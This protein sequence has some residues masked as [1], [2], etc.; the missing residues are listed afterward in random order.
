MSEGRPTAQEERGDLVV[1]TRDLTKCYGENVAVDRLNLALR[2]GEVFGLL[3]PNGAG[4]TTTILML[5]GLTEPTSGKVEVLGLD[6]LTQATEVKR[7]VGYLPDHVGFYDHM[8]GLENLLYTAALND[9]EP[10]T[11]RARA[12][13]LLERVGLAADG[14]R[15]VREYSHGMRQRLGIADALIKEPEILILDEPTLGLDPQGTQDVLALIRELANDR[16]MTIL[17]SSHLLYQVQAVCDRVGIFVRGRMVVE[18]PV[19]RLATEAFAGSGVQ[20][21]VGLLPPVER[22]LEAIRSV[23]GVLAVEPGDEPSSFLV[24]CDRDV[25]PRIARAVADAGGS[26]TH[27]QARSYSLDDIYRTY[28]KGE[29]A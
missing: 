17:L 23:E 27:L 18:G 8:T 26:L 24:R 1:Q 5:L 25:R 29:Q 21:E 2:R 12:L 28:F 9:L 19:D 14:D 22:A 20:V 13:G 11:A 10:A 4:K 3:G 16:G 15:P 6:P 7:R